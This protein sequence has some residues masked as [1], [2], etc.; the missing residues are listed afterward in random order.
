MSELIYNWLN[1]EVGM[2]P[3][4]KDFKEDF[5]T[6]YKYGNLLFKLSLIT[7]DHFLKNYYDAYDYFSKKTNF[8]HLTKDLKQTCN[9]DLTP[10]MINPILEK[11]LTAA[12]NLIYKIRVS[13]NKKKINF[14][15]IK[16]I[17][18]FADFEEIKKRFDDMA[19]FNVESIIGKEDNN[20][21]KTY[22]NN[23]ETIFTSPK[24]NKKITFIEQILKKTKFIKKGSMVELP[25]E[26]YDSE[27]KLNK[28][29]DDINLTNDNNFDNEKK[30]IDNNEQIFKLT[31]SEK[32][33]PI[34]SSNY[35][36]QK[37]D[38]H[39][40]DIN[41]M[42]NTDIGEENRKILKDNF[43]VTSFKENL[44]T[45]GFYI[46]YE[47]LKFLNGSFNIDMSQDT[48]MAKIKEQLKDRIILKKKFQLEKEN[49]QKIDLGKTLNPKTYRN[50]FNKDNSLFH[51]NITQKEES[52][53]NS[54]TNRR[55]NYDYNIREEKKQNDLSKR[56]N[57]F[58]TI[59]IR[60]NNTKE[61]SNFKFQFNEPE[62]TFN[63]SNFFSQLNKLNLKETILK[64]EIK[65]KNIINDYPL[66]RKITHQ[67]IDYTFEGY[68]Y[69]IENIKELLELPEYKEWNEKF[70]N[71]KPIKEPFFD[72]ELF[73]MKKLYSLIGEKEKMKWTID[74]EREVLD[75][76]NYAGEWDDR[77]IIPNNIRG[78]SIEFND[79][80]HN[81]NEDFEPTKS[82]IEDVSMSKFPVKNYRFADLI[83]NVLE[84]KFPS[85]NNIKNNQIKGKWD[86]IPIKICFIGYPLSGKKT[87][88]EI[89][90]NKFPL[91]KI[92][93]VYDVINNKINEWNEIN[94]PIENNPKFKNLKPNQ[95][96]EMNEEKNKKIE[97]FKSLNK[98]IMSYLE[99]ENEN[100]IPS[101]DLLF[102]YLVEK[103]E[104]EFPIIND[105][106]ILKEI[107][108]RQEKLKEL[109][110]KLTILKKENEESNKPNIKDEQNLQNEIE[111]IEKETYKGF[112]IIDYPK[113]LNQCVLLE[114]YLT[115]YIDPS[116][117]PKPIKEVELDLL[118]NLIDI[119]FKIKDDNSIRKSGLDF[120]INLN[121]N[122]DII[123][124]RL[125]DIKYD[126][127]TGKVYNESQINIDGKINIDKKIYER[128][129]NEVPEFKGEK[130]ENLKK[131]YNENWNKIER[132]Y[133]KFGFILKKNNE[134]NEK[135]DKNEKNEIHGFQ[136]EKLENIHLFQQ[137]DNLETKEDISNYIIDNLLKMI[138][139]EKDKKEKN[140]YI[141]LKHD[142]EDDEKEKIH[143][144]KIKSQ[145][146]LLKKEKEKE[147]ELSLISDC[148]DYV[149]REII[150]L[151]EKYKNGL[152]EF[153]FFN[154]KQYDDLCKRFNLIQRK[155]EQFLE[156]PTE[157]RK[158]IKVFINKYNSFREKYPKIINTEVVVEGFKN[159]IEDLNNKL[160]LYVRQKETECIIELNEIFSSQYF[161]NEMEKFYLSIIDLIK[162]E[163]DKFLTSI[164]IICIIF[165]KKKL[166]EEEEKNINKKKKKKEINSD[167]LFEKIPKCLKHESLNFYTKNIKKIFFN[168][169]KIILNQEEKIKNLEKYIK[170]NSSNLN[171][172]T[173]SKHRKKTDINSSLTTHSKFHEHSNE[174][175]VKKIIDKE[176]LKY[177]YR[178]LVIKYFALNFLQK[179]QYT[180][181][182]VHNNMDSWIIVSVRLQD[183]AMQEVKKKLLNYVENMK[184][185]PIDLFD[186][187]HMDQFSTIDEIYHQI[188]YEHILGSKKRESHFHINFNYDVLSLKLF[189]EDL[190]KFNVENNVIC[191]NV[192]KE[193]FIK[194]VFFNR[195][196]L[197]KK[198]L[199]NG[200][201]EPL[202]FLSYKE[203]MNLVDKF[204]YDYREK[205][206]FDKFNIHN[207]FRDIIDKENVYEEY[208]NYG[209]FFTVISIIGSKVIQNEEIDLINNYFKDKI[210][211]GCFIK[212][213]DFFNYKFWFE[214]DE[215]LID[216]IESLKQFLF[217]IWQDEKGEL[218]NLKEFLTSLSPEKLGGNSKDNIVKFD[219]YNFA[220]C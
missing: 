188:N 163:T 79:I 189:Y 180:R 101:D 220:F 10:N 200:I 61:F 142:D 170:S 19:K 192:F 103:I 53:N 211:K 44:N 148:A 99:D 159:D 81:L 181:D 208:I 109:N 64:S 161:E 156:I 171:E 201:S 209:G 141:D 124:E 3:H 115:N 150:T 120:I 42:L 70:V 28:N 40:K 102:K 80:F 158:L 13:V 63:K 5:Y 54:C 72:K 128:L 87:Q 75:Y 169:I 199:N 178:V 33:N 157:K 177:K 38:L 187:F 110:N 127:I 43:N 8:D 123:N 30:T 55:L 27:V 59:M 135:N 219:Y 207:E 183:K 35:K 216:K 185:I 137:I 193:M 139:I 184:N 100:K 52:F 179:L 7:L 130:F 15:N 138:H 26:F 204:K 41:Y 16:T 119:R 215:Y 121:T 146:N 151:N 68:L 66:I 107:I 210:S 174:E 147:K 197:N 89:I 86:Y 173:V 23:Q 14:D 136:K 95:I 96:D 105:E 113:N 20:T 112:I 168:C 77:Y 122:E 213:D 165:G 144:E 149:Y 191:F 98:D 214:D 153:I 32:L 111:N 126:P 160:W 162:L 202:K 21:N 195:D 196:E 22:D 218:F 104:S 131:E 118:S 46:N 203:V 172:S 125:K 186:N 71:G 206:D 65:K 91:I 17:D 108:T 88:A 51:L 97:E 129:E 56:I 50:F 18:I 140:I 47:K 85:N 73:E 154:D 69:Q 82:Q 145:L 36:L 117:I 39:K 2:Y 74:K 152:R 83:N 114:K 4:I 176:K 62:I 9:L 84:Y 155:F 175:I 34:K 106:V 60:T 93:S 167:L 6:G 194:E 143:V 25:S 190:K 94:E 132:F 12:M 49:Q 164:D 212:K 166:N 31:K 48:V 24:K 90:N 205:D 1:N 57:K 76:I 78:V 58:K 217:E 133:S 134:N 182:R 92:I 11:D 67:I 198:N 37:H 45:I 29:E 116:T